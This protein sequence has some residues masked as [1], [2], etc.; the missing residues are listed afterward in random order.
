M[1]RI[2][3]I[4]HGTVRIGL[5]ISDEMELVASPLK[6]I[7]LQCRSNVQ[8]FNNG[9]LVDEIPLVT[10]MTIMTKEY[11]LGSFKPRDPSKFESFPYGRYDPA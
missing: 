6:T 11:N 3:G 2:L 9:G 7:Q 1:S 5:A 8:V 4:D 10:V